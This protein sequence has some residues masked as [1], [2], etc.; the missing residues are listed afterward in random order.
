VFQLFS[1]SLGPA[2]PGGDV[3]GNDQCEKL[4]KCMMSLDSAKKV[5]EL[6]ELTIAH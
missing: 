4:R 1:V 5:D 6:L 3:I 2:P